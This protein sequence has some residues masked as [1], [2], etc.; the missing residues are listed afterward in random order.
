MNAP[1]SIPIRTTPR[2]AEVS[3]FS[4]LCSDD[5]EYLGVPDGSLRSSFEHCSSIVKKADELGYQNVL[6]P[7]GFVPGQDALGFAFSMAVLTK[8]INQLV[9]LRMGEVHPPMLARAISSL[10]HIAKGRLA[11]NIISSDMPGLK[12]SNEERYSRS[13]EIIQFLKQC[14]TQETVEFHGRFYDFHPLPTDP[15]KP[16]QQNG[17]PLLYFGGISP[18]A[19]ALCAKHCDVFLMWPETT[20]LLTET[21]RGVA[22]QA[23]EHDRK[24][25]FGLRIHVIVRETESEAREAAR[26]LVSKLDDTKGLEIKSRSQ[27]SKSAGVLRQDALREAADDEG[28]IEEHIWSGIGRA[29]S[30]CGS[31]IVGDPDQVYAKLQS[32]MDLGMRSFILS[33]YPHLE[34]CD[35]FAKYVLP[36]MQT[37]RLNEVQGRLPKET[38]VTPLTTGKRK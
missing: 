9:A 35:L 26:K 23:A 28:Y 3:W 38:P 8:Q 29:R 11:L 19:Q 31:A 21:M 24:I 10:D 14:W 34:E 2:I 32:Y 6:L 33:G 16:Y 1:P 30:G 5:F 20:P 18:M 36:R 27:D 12:E 22:A 17:G 4:A 13:D 25:D 7:S 15:V 37:C